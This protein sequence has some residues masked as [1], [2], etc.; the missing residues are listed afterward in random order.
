MIFIFYL[1]DFF[2]FFGNIW[3]KKVSM[4]STASLQSQEVMKN[5][6]CPGDLVKLT[7]TV[8][9]ED[10]FTVDMASTDTV[11]E[12]K[13]MIER[14]KGIS[15]SNQ[16]LVYR[17]KKLETGSLQQNKIAKKA[18]LL[19]MKLAVETKE[20]EGTT[21]LCRTGC[22][23]WGFVKELFFFAFSHCFPQKHNNRQYVFEML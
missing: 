22:G 2:G 15:V 9:G 3:L 20:E 8:V 23:F 17:G 7:V 14:S 1:C 10:T 4:A 18:A 11:E 21:V 6:I 5:N 16:K 12:L 13:K 19:L